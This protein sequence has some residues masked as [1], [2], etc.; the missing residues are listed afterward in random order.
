LLLLSFR[1]NIYKQGNYKIES[2]L[3]IHFLDGYHP[4]KKSG[5][6]ISCP[7]KKRICKYA[8]NHYPHSA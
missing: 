6:I 8:E 7:V 4:L 5:E 2:V 3:F 1:I